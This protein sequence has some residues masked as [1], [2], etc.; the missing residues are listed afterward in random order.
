[1]TEVVVR[2]EAITI[3]AQTIMS[4]GFHF[5]K[6]LLAQ[7]KQ[8]KGGAIKVV[9]SEVILKETSKRLIEKTQSVKDASDAARR[10]ASEFGILQSECHAGALDEPDPTTVALKR[11]EGFLEA[12]G[13]ETADSTGRRNT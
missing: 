4:K 2:Y 3:D 7:L 6:G 9:I 10:A 13:A 12:I 1:M 8:F 5:E 11:I